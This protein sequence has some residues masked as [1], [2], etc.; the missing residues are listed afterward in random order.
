MAKLI[1]NSKPTQ[2]K[3][4]S[5]IKINNALT[6]TKISQNFTV[7]DLM[8]SSYSVF[9]GIGQDN[10]TKRTYQVTVNQD[11]SIILNEIIAGEE[12]ATS[13]IVLGNKY[14]NYVTK[15]VWSLP[16]DL[17]SEYYDFGLIMTTTSLSQPFK[18]SLVEEDGQLV[19]WIN[20][21]ITAQPTIWN[22]L[23][24]ALEKT[25]TP[26]TSNN[27]QEAFVSNI[28]TGT[29]SN[30]FL[31]AEEIGDLQQYIANPEQTTPICSTLLTCGD[32]I[33]VG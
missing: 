18:L 29:V 30:N 6:T 7:N 2:I 16:E 28:F 25:A 5:S 3:T 19:S 13:N 27:Q 32:T 12:V 14:D 24:I 33:L 8:K 26:I 17:D 1:K 22:L 21:N 9:R 11:G 23:L 10:E 15:L 20:F 4:D 31:T